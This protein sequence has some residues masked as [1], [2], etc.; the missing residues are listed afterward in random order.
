MSRITD[1]ILRSRDTLA[2][3]QGNRW[4]DDRLLRLVD[5]AQKDLCKNSGLLRDRVTIKLVINQS[6]Y[7]LPDT[8][9]KLDRVQMNYNGVRYLL[10]MKSH[11]ELDDTTK[12]WEEETGTPTTVV[13]D[14]QKKKELKLYPTP[15]A[16]EDFPVSVCPAEGFTS[17]LDNKGIDVHG[18]VANIDGVYITAESVDAYG[19][20]SDWAEASNEIIIDFVKSP[21]TITT[22]LDEL[23]V[24]EDFDQAIKY[25]IT[26]MALRDD[27]D[28]QNRTFGAEELS[29]YNVILEDAKVQSELDFTKANRQYQSRYQGAFNE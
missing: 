4:T 29:L 14:K 3:P 23:E 13:Y 11:L 18:V 1:I 20:L 16:Q 6:T 10:P 22:D 26:G 2:D 25:Y 5:E 24:T 17:Y 8:F 19:I 12:N 9:H 15:I 7:S 21:I 27:M 28:T